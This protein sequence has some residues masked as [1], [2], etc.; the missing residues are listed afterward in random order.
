MEIV[1]VQIPKIATKSKYNN[2]YDEND[3]LPHH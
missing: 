1:I 2:M 3:T